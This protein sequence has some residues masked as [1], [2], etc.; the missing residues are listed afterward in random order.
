MS[1]RMTCC[2]PSRACS[3][4]RR[5]VKFILCE[6]D[7]M[8]TFTRNCPAHTIMLDNG[9]RAFVTESRAHSFGRRV[10]LTC[11][12]SRTE[13]GKGARRQRIVRLSLRPG[14]KMDDGTFDKVWFHVTLT[15]LNR[16]RKILI[17]VNDE[18]AK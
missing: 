13:D 1:S 7:A 14:W 11:S 16:A 9:E 4:M 2:T 6:D 17:S 12:H 5:R 15:S 10:S 3:R 8:R 18:E